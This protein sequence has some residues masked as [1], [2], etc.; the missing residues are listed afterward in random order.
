M[1]NHVHLL[2]TPRVS[3]PKLTQRLKGFTARQ[4]NRILNR[5][6]EAFWQGE[7]YDHW[8]RDREEG[9]RIAAYIEGNP[10][11]AGLAARPEDYRWSSAWAGQASHRHDCRCGRPGGPLHKE[12]LQIPEM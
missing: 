2:V 8:V 6:G 12:L 10:V 1:P 11:R 5:T 9:G 7:S 4:A 3:L